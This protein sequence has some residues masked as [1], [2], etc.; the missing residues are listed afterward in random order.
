MNF[1][2]FPRGYTP[3]VPPS[4]MTETSLQ[5]QPANQTVAS[6]FLTRSPIVCSG[7]KAS[8]KTKR[9]RKVWSSQEDTILV[10]CLQKVG[11][12]KINWTAVAR[13]VNRKSD[14]SPRTGKQC[15]ERWQ[16][17]LRPNIKKGNWSREEEEMIIS[18]YQ[19]FPNEWSSISKIMKNR[20]DNDIKNK[21]NSMQRS[22][23]L[24]K[25]KR[26]R[27]TTVTDK[28]DSGHIEPSS[29]SIDSNERAERSFVCS[30][31]HGANKM[32]GPN[33]AEEVL[34][35]QGQHLP[36]DALKEDRPNISAV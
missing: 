34:V 26:A 23:A 8:T 18:L 33:S 22:L 29:V 5:R 17:H 31:R 16:N 2:F 24:K 4:P 28:L 19:T 36:P 20:T 35:A 10:D 27:T 1:N 6:N 7:Y 21:W 32:N 9:K 11:A 3:N 13:K 25:A 30:L 15:R 12:C 14:D